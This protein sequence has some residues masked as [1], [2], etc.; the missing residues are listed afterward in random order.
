MCGEPH[1]YTSGSIYSYVSDGCIKPTSQPQC[2]LNLYAIESCSICILH[3]RNMKLL[4][5]EVA[6]PYI[7]ALY[8]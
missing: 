7:V 5:M 3:M 6:R 8:S 2:A 4:M 1:S